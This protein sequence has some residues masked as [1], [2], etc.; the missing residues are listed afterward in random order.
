MVKNFGPTQVLDLIEDSDA[1][2]E[3]YDTIILLI[4]SQKKMKNVSL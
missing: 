2:G 1:D 3:L 4:S